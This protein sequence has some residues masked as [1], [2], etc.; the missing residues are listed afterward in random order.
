MEDKAEYNLTTGGVNYTIP[1]Y[2]R[3]GIERYIKT[4]VKAGDFLM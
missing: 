2:M 4:R 1:E 3:E